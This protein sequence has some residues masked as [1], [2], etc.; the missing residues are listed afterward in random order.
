MAKNKSHPA[1]ATTPV[2]TDA[3]LFRQAVGDVKRI[4]DDHTESGPLPPPPIPQQ[5]RLDEQ[6]VLQDLLSDHYDPDALDL[7]DEV[8]FI[9]AGL[10]RNVLRK[11][12]RGQYSIGGEL[13]LHGMTL[14]KARQALIVFLQEAGRTQKQCVRIIHG[15]GLRSS[16]QGP[17][18]KPMVAKWLTQREEVLA[19][20]T[21]RPVD[22]GSGAVYVLLKK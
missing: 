20:C 3:E 2:Q 12:R 14:P 17:V 1:P 16:N 4:E 8:T 22:G 7:G 9:R 15:K 18:L 19:F 21:A 13:D 10:Q 6:A 11:L 5:H